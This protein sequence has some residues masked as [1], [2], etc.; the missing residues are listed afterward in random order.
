M[1]LVIIGLNHNTA[2][3]EVREKMAV[4]GENY[5]SY[6]K[7]LLD[8][9]RVLEVCIV[10][11]CNRVEY[12]IVTGL[13]MCY[14]CNGIDII[15]SCCDMEAGEISKY[16][17]CYYGSDAVKHVFA[18]ASGLDSLVLG[19]PQIFG[20]IKGAFE[21][22]KEFRGMKN[23]LNRVHESTLKIAKRVR[24][25]TGI[26]E[27]PVS[28]SYAA[29]ELAK[30]IFGD[31]S[32]ANALIIGAGEMCELAARH[33]VGSGIGSIT[34]T[35]RTLEKAEKLAAE[36]HGKAVAFDKFHEILHEADIII[37]STGSP[38]YV[39]HG[40]M[41]KAAMSKR[42]YKPMFF[43]DIAVP[44]DIDP[45]GANVEYT[46]IYDMDDLK[47]V[48]EA[49]KKEREKEA[50]KGWEM[51]NTAVSQF[52]ESME[53]LKLTP[54]IVNLRRSFEDKKNEELLKFC[55]KNKITDPDEMARL[56]YL[57]SSTLNK[58]LH[59]PLTNLKRHGA[60]KDKYTVGDAIDLIFGNKS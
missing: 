2:S 41:I 23:F 9:E 10:S 46:Y 15:S 24:T 36:F 12:Y 29:V 7:K 43:I 52:E 44:R 35:N 56:D 32:G 37:S 19:E 45:D 22:S 48:V 49:N 58:I 3:V 16:A 6:Y 59:K 25:Y 5:E 21:N 13:S 50:K 60:D 39:V 11:T 31:L 4:K 26:S 38:D 55:E 1:Q 20:Q 54:V 40:E 18:V 27:N 51:V 34:L 17:Y 28:V 53:S 33:L 14:R 42:K 47:S 30:K 8:D 57:I